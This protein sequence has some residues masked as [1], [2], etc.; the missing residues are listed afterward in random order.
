MYNKV[1]YFVNEKLILKD[2]GKCIRAFLR[3]VVSVRSVASLNSLA[4]KLGPKQKGVG[5]KPGAE[6]Y[7]DTPITSRNTFI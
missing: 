3:S 4:F 6:G 1:G 5:A 7:H 2:K